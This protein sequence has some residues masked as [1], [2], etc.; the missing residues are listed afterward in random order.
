[1]IYMRRLYAILAAVILTAC[2]QEVEHV[3]V[4]EL[5]CPE[6]TQEA[7]P[8][9]ASLGFKIYTNGEYEGTVESDWL[10]VAEFPGKSEFVTS[11]DSLTLV[12]GHNE[13]DTREGKVILTMETRKVELKVVQ[14]GDL[15][16]EPEIFVEK[17]DSTSSTL[18]FRFGEGETAAEMIAR[19]YIFGLFR[20]EALTDTVVCHYVAAGSSIWNK[21]VPAFT[22]GGLE[23]G[24]RYYFH[25]SDTSSVT[26]LTDSTFL[27]VC[28]SS[29]VVSLST[30]AF[31]P[32]QT[33]SGSV[34]AGSVIL[35]EDFS[36]IP[37]NGDELNAAAGFRSRNVESFVAPSGTRPEG[38]FGNRGFECQLFDTTGF[39]VAVQES[40]LAGWS[41]Y[42]Q[43]G[44]AD[45]RQKMVFARVGY[46]KMGGYSYASD[47]VT[48]A[49]SD[50]PAGMVAKVKVDFRASR[51]SSDSQ[52]MVVAAV[53]GSEENNVF[54][55]TDTL[56][57]KR[58]DLNPVAGWNP[59]SVELTKVQP[60]TRILIGPDFE[61]VGTGNGKSQHRMFI[62]D[63]VVT[64]MA[65]TDNGLVV[66]AEN[67][68]ATSSTLTFSFG[69]GETDSDKAGFTY[70]FG[71]YRDEALTDMVVCHK[72]EGGHKCWNSKAPKFVFAGLES[73]TG[74]YFSA[75]NE[76]TGKRSETI[77][78]ATDAFNVVQ[79]GTVPVS[80]GAVILAED[81]SLIPWGGDYLASAAGFKASDVTAFAAPSGNCPEGKFDV[82]PYETPL[83][84]KDGFGAAVRGSRLADWAV[85]EQEKS[86]GKTL[87][88]HAGYLKM[89]GYS[90]VPNIVTPSLA[91]IPDGKVANV[92]VDFKASRYGTDPVDIVVSAVAGEAE[93]SSSTSANN[94]TVSERT[95]VQLSLK[96]ERGWNPYSVE[97]DNISNGER[98]LIG[99]DFVKSGR[100]NG[101]SQH[102]MLL[103]DIVVTVLE[104]RDNGMKVEAEHIASS[105]STL[106]F[107][108]GEGTDDKQ[109]R[110]YGYSFG[111]YR[112]EAM[113]DLVV[114]HSIPAGSTLWYSSNAPTFV[115]AG[116][117]RN[118]EYW[119]SVTN[120]STGKSLD[121]PLKASTTDFTLVNTAVDQV[122]P[123]TVI[124]AEDFSELPWHGD[125]LH[126]AVGWISSDVSEYVSP[127]GDCPSGT[128]KNR[129]SEDQLYGG[130]LKDASLGSRLADWSILRQGDDNAG[131]VYAK[132]GHLKLG[133]GS[134]CADIVT[135]ELQ[136]PED[137]IAKV[138]VDFKASRY[139]SDPV[140]SIVSA[141]GG[142]STDNAFA[143]TSRKDVRFE[144][145]GAAG[146]SPYSFEFENVRR[147]MR[148][149]IGPDFVTSGRGSGKSQHRMFLDDVKVTVV[150]IIKDIW[151]VDASHTAASSSTLTF[152]FG[153]GNA[154]KDYGYTFALYR[155]EALTDLVVSHSVPAGSSIWPSSGPAFTF[156]GLEQNT[157]YYFNATNP[158]TGNVSR[159]VAAKTDSFTVV[160]PDKLQSAGIGTVILAEDF[161]ILCWNGDA[162][163]TAAGWRSS[164]LS[165]FN[166]P[167]GD[168]SSSGTYGNSGYECPLFYA[169]GGLG[170]AVG[171]SRLSGWGMRIPS[172]AVNAQKSLISRVGYLK[173]GG[174]S[175]APQIV[176]P[177]LS[178]IPEGKKARLKVEF[179][180][181]RYDAD[182][183]ENLLVS[184]MKGTMGENHV[185][186][187]DRRNDV[188][189]KMDISSPDLKQYSVE[190]EA[191]A[192]SR[193]VIGPDFETTGKGQGSSQYRM[194]ID[195][196]VITILEISDIQ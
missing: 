170:G 34:A 144:L 160:E 124:L 102:R 126:D 143:V 60:D 113:T 55:L 141:V 17:V 12:F 46:L 49:L 184:A 10:S 107:R 23:S 173:L 32:V 84:H 41:A 76:D 18:T 103:D 98:I 37:W 93:V 177:E 147:G 174:Y 99:P 179:L 121:T 68:A 171:D 7:G 139:G 167:S 31:T 44:A 108:F 161:S 58:F 90:F 175:Y 136:I 59:Y 91:G 181:A 189:M 154:P 27:A 117:E 169:D 129:D 29:D 116:L 159:T 77:Y 109:K 162:L 196:I 64:L 119:F 40:R 47:L 36:E 65:V 89:G 5:G 114:R 166:S 96:E 120:T 66:E 134:W 142:T 188:K 39:G 72:V 4:Y 100:G 137:Y 115:F 105:S 178:C 75:L 148:I 20:D 127:Y 104:L 183:A 70:S 21:A 71:L 57:C 130:T 74:Y 48:P 123:G 88:A 50:I 42:P 180:G 78:A 186:V 33:G 52:A 62:D 112:D 14:K 53:E 140:A 85:L 9:A 195:E 2:V 97:F 132:S 118:T 138:R 22:F 193:I 95:D 151:K 82:A 150:D 28:K 87:F 125:Y 15:T 73:A 155:D 133:G 6:S 80:E 101:D 110:S 190:L 131:R 156:G 163:N 51:Y 172:D 157:T 92:R 164:D 194:Y 153:E 54:A 26:P 152:K 38:G 81:F 165:G 69:E 94:F 35:A 61:K 79:V 111:L 67:I 45:N 63:I 16:R 146:W 25:V 191:D 176:T 83:T 122:E 24:T 3:T 106:I 128:Y 13:G 158:E 135:P 182:E 185:F 43:K 1:M 8:E 30:T 168:C 19:P 187:P 56:S 86:A 11:A 149:L 145:S 192:A